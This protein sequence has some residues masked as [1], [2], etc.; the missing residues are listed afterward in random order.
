MDRR[1]DIVDIEAIEQAACADLYAAA[2]ASLADKLGLEH[3]RIDDGLLL[4]SRGL[5]NLVFNRLVGFGVNMPSREAG[6]DQAIRAFQRAGVHNW[7]IQVAPGTDVLARLLAARGFSRH[8]RTWAK[9]ARPPGP[10]TVASTDLTV[11]EIGRADADRF[12]AVVIE[13]FGLPREAGGWFAALAGRSRWRCFLAMDGTQAVA[14]GAVFIDG[15]SAWLGLGATLPSH[16]G[17]GAQTALLT[18]RLTAS[19]GAELVTTETGLPLKGEASPSYNNIQRAG[20]SVAYERPN[21][22]HP[23]PSATAAAGSEG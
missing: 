9:F 15:K 14:A 18:A 6:I 22:R 2:P 4:V 20:F 12:G 19:V 21:F 13:G 11:R 10:P 23:D 7:V 5:D 3:S 8:P 17:R 1:D 16:R